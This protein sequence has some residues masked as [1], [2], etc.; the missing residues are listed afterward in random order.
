M[1][2]GLQVARLKRGSLALLLL[3]TKPIVA[4]WCGLRARMQVFAWVFLCGSFWAMSWMRLQLVNRTVGDYSGCPSHCFDGVV[5]GSDALIFAILLALVGLS[6]LMP[7]LIRTLLAMAGLLLIV[8][9]A[10][11]I[12][13]FDLLNN[14]L[15]LPDILRYAGDVRLNS[16]VA[17]PTFSS[18]RSVALLGL[19]G[20]TGLSLVVLTWGRAPGASRA[21]GLWPIL[22]V[23]LLLGM[24]EEADEV[25]H[26]AANNYRD[27]ITINLP[28]GE[29]K[30]YS[31]ALHNIL[32]HTA[33]PPSTCLAPTRP[34]HP[35]PVIL[36]VVES[37]SL[38]HSQVMSGLGHELPQLDKLAQKYSYIESFYANGFTTDG[39]LIA[40]LTGHVPL[41]TVHR[42]QSFNAYEGF[43]SDRH[44]AFK[45]L[46]A[47]GISTWYFRTA[48]LG[49]LNTGAWLRHLGFDHVEGPEN[50]FYQGLP[51]GSFNEPGDHAL[52]QRFLHWYA[53]E[54]DNDHFF[55][56]LQTT[57]THPP[58]RIP[59]QP[60]HNE[61][62]AFRYADQEIGEFVR[63][64]EQQHFFDRGLL[65]ITGDHR[66]MTVRRPGEQ[67]L[68]GMEAP[69]RI[70]AVLLGA[71]FRQGGPLPGRWQQTDF[72]PS[73]LAANGLRSCTDAFAG[74]FLGPPVEPEVILHAQG[75]A[76]DR[77]L[78]RLRGQDAPLEI[79]LDGDQTH[80]VTP[81]PSEPLDVVRE[82]NRQ[83]AM[84]PA[85]PDN[86]TENLLRW[87]GLTS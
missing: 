84:R 11:D 6:W 9:F 50:A 87:Y 63:T 8:C 14:R 5:F 17:L 29:D 68:L 41:P 77:A 64:L 86:F 32:D 19:T 23:P 38:Y 1:F 72:L 53:N 36:L 48:D 34:P 12:A 78:V 7:R 73:L 42:Y 81:P 51:R 60:G 59:G 33:A 56:V 75:L 35:R 54:R 21:S 4:G 25:G 61:N 62:N 20:L 27:L 71:E 37:L 79:E 76:R 67:A 74:R 70:P 40:L 18:T 85:A 57:T 80:W 66:S 24:H 65:V 16:T 82:I 3:L 47:A 22:V 49:F 45:Q 2:T 44:Q 69:A 15:N 83:R 26:I 39:G 10:I 46:R 28:S 55:A 43:E 13:V 58:F 31:A 30:P 52:Y